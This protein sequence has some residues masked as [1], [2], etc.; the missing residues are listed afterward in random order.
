MASVRFYHPLALILLLWAGAA[1]AEDLQ[2]PPQLY[3]RPV[4]AVDPGTHTAQINDAA[5]DHNGRWALT[6]SDDK[7]VRIWSLADGKLERTIRLPAGP[8]DVGKV[9]A[10]AMSPEGDLIAAGGWTRWTDADPQEQIYLFD[11][12]KSTL[13]KRIEGLPGAV[14]FLHSRLTAAVSR[15]GRAVAGCASTQGIAAGTRRRGTTTMATKSMAPTSRPTA[16]SPPRHTMVGCVFTHPTSR[17][18]FVLPSSSSYPGSCSGS[19]SALP[20]ARALLSAIATHRKSICSTGIASP[21]FPLL[22]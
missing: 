10:V 8:G 15:L 21:H 14:D 19:R 13:V 7:T 22:T 6:G 11:R 1:R 20:T 16:G 17:A 4:L 9:Y 3:D 18:R 12:E 2:N 5:A